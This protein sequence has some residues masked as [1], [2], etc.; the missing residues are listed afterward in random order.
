[1]VATM[2]SLG[3]RPMQIYTSQ[4]GQIT[5]AIALMRGGAGGL[6][7]FLAGP[8]GMALTTASIV[9]M[10]F[11]SRLFEADRAAKA[12]EAGADGLARAQ[13][14]LGDVFDLVSGKLKTQNELLILNARLMAINMRAEATAKRASARE[15]LRGAGS[16]G[17]PT[18]F[19]AQTIG[20]SGLGQTTGERNAQALRQ[21]MLDI[22]SGKITRDQALKASA[23]MDF[24]GV[25]TTREAFQQALIDAT[26]ANI[27]D[28]AAD[29]IDQSLDS[30]Q[31]ASELREPGKTTKPRAS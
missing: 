2:Y 1:D 27:N 19:E 24:T 13:S 18:F 11:I 3:M 5:Q 6:V 26:V 29:L 30:G 4:I 10:P 8:W 23:T 9:M 31:L 28:R 17:T 25:K 15:S 22:G 16:A 12:A 21:L 14:A 7:G 20:I